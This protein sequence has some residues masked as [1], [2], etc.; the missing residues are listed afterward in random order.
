MTKTVHLRTPI[1]E[2]EIRSL[3]LN[4]VVYIS[5]EAY[6]MLYADHYT[7][8]MD[9]VRQGKKL[10]DSMNFKDGVIYNTGTIW[11]RTA[12]GKY[13]M[14]AL[15]A[16]TSSKF[17]AQTPDFIKAMGIR[18]VIGK[19]GM[20][21]KTLEA[22]KQYGCVYL[23]IVGGCSAVYTPHARIVDDYCP[24]LMPAD[25]QRL[26]FEMNEFGPLFVAMDAAGNS[27]YE[28]CAHTAQDRLPLIYKKLNINA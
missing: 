26:K 2:Q 6:E 25:N 1:S 12:D 20:D 5:G 11:R 13:D 27:L 14:R 4:D 21:L 19:G 9:M 28:Q 23:A 7:L 10:P 3:N 15:C 18:A 17:N 16:T 22:M 8:V 24:E